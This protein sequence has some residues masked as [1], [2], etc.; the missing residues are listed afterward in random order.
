[1]PTSGAAPGALPVAGAP[2]SKVTI[3]KLVEGKPSPLTVVIGL[4]DGKNL[5]ITSGVSEGDPI[6]VAQR[7]G[8]GGAVRNGAAAGSAAP[9]AGNAQPAPAGAASG[10]NAPAGSGAPTKGSGGK[11]TRPSGQAT[12]ST[13]SAPASNQQ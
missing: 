6:I 4:S 9:A 12:D 11:R 7:R 5:E 13:G 10:A 3:W 2:G 8:N 1:V